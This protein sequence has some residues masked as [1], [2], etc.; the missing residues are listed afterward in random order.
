MQ[1]AGDE[2]NKRQ[3][4]I[5]IELYRDDIYKTSEYLARIFNVS[6]KTIRNEIKNI[7]TFQLDLGFEITSMRS[8]GY[9]LKVIDEEIFKYHILSNATKEI[10]IDYNN[11][12]NRVQFIMGKL[13][14]SPTYIKLE[15]LADLMYV[16][17]TTVQN[18][19]KLVKNNFEKYNLE[20]VSKPRYGLKV[21]GE[22][23]QKRFCI[24][25]YLFDHENLKD[26]TLQF[27]LTED[28]SNKIKE[29]I[30]DTIATE[31]FNVT[32]MTINN[33]FV[34]IV[35]ALGRI[36]GNGNIDNFYYDS[37]SG[38]KEYKIANEI[39]LKVEKYFDVNISKEEV[40]YIALHL[41]GQGI[42]KNEEVISTLIETYHL[43]DIIFKMLDEIKKTVGIDL[44]EDQ[45]LK[46]A[47][48]L[49]LS[50]AFN[51]YK[52]HMNFRNPLLDMLKKEYPFAFDAALI[53][54]KVIE[55]EMK[56]KI[57]ESEV[58]YIAMHLGGAMER[59]E[60]EKERIKTLIV[61][62]SGVSSSQLLKYRIQNLFEKD[63]EVM[64]I[65]EMYKVKQH[66][67]PNVDLIIS[68][69]PLDVQ[70]ESVDIIQVNP[71]L[72][73]SDIEQITNYINKPK[74][75]LRFF[76]E[77]L[78]FLKQKYETFNEILDFVED[79]LLKDNLIYS[80]FKE[81]VIEREKVAPTSY[82]NYVAAPHPITSASKESFLVFVTLEKP[83][84]WSGKDVQWLCFICLEKDPK[85]IIEMDFV[86][87]KLS[88]VINNLE[89][90]MTLLSIDDREKFLLEIKTL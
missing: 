83:I 38:T 37:L 73:Q 35:I 69:V 34:H 11:Q 48:I 2:M 77:E 39:V 54:A 23:F 28:E 27:E 14:L 82:G 22:E 90:V 13:L 29:I 63:I 31:S 57:N 76:R 30:L 26:N 53:C 21:I 86:Y 52:Y 70:F 84:E 7:E 80:D 67:I 32:D 3:T 33:L 12:S 66:D 81:K 47:L 50:T 89:L 10:T 4:Q 15:V 62:A 78:V 24:S 64:G 65:S 18:D 44:I 85:E 49:H 8:K 5:V 45:E 17:K 41:I 88:K 9:K 71:I 55:K 58:G 46:K 60:K 19:L 87:E 36:K 75:E 6:S 16:S 51:R 56:Y 59:L 74:K 40:A 79:K 20:I 42:N 68:T 72:I 1:N 43:E 61:C 25:E